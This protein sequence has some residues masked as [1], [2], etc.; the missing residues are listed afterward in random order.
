[1]PG[2]LLCGVLESSRFISANAEHVQV[3]QQA[4]Q[5]VAEK[6]L[7]QFLASC[8]LPDQETTPTFEPPGLSPSEILEWTFLL[9]TLNFCFW[10]D[11]ATLF[12]SSHAGKQWTGYWSLCAA[13]LK[14]VEDGMPIYRPSCYGSISTKQMQ[15][16]F[17]SETHVELPLL[18]SRRKNLIEA[19]QVLNKEFNGQVSELIRRSEKSA[20]KLVVLLVRHFPSYRDTGYYKGR[21]VSFLKRAQIFVADVWHRFGGKGP[22]EFND[23]TSLTMFADYRVPQGLLYLEVLEYSKELMNTLRAGQ[24]LEAGGEWEAEIRGCSIWAVEL[25][26]RE[27]CQLIESLP[28]SDEVGVAGGG[29]GGVVINAAMLDFFLW[30]YTKSHS[31]RPALADCPIHH[32]LTIYY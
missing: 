12:T 19:A 22:G 13:L 17:R 18:S 21:E 23:I 31:N 10:S 24:H 4:A 15:Q 27:M 28:D 3:N 29:G 1:M 8:Q 6:L 9:D 7:P 5:Q 16:I 32:T 2:E 14:A 11:E 26:R 25:I 20:E 30:N